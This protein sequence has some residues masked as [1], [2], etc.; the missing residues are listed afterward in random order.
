MRTRHDVIIKKGDVVMEKIPNEEML[1]MTRVKSTVDQHQQG[2]V[3]GE[4]NVIGDK[5]GVQTL[6]SAP[7]PL[8]I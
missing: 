3:G 8:V 1:M 5:N 2:V 4:N 6:P 7:I